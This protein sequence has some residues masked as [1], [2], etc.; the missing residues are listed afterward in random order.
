VVDTGSR[1]TEPVAVREPL[2]ALIVQVPYGRARR[3]LP[4]LSVV[5]VVVSVSPEVQPV[6]AAWVAWMVAPLTATPPRF[7]TT[8][9]ASRLALPP[10]VVAP[11]LLA[12]TVPRL[13]PL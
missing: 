5:V 10:E 13:P 2:V 6:P 12:R 9:T 8:S 3:S 7:T 11:G 1:V 4:A